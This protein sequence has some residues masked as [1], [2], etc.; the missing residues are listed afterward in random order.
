MCGEVCGEVEAE[1]WEAVE[2][3]LPGRG[4]GTL[5]LLE[6]S[7]VSAREQ[8]KR[9]CFK[10]VYFTD[11][12]DIFILYMYLHTCSTYC[13]MGVQYVHVWQSRVEIEHYSVAH[14][15]RDTVFKML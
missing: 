6:R 9:T 5:R 15:N 4:R 1:R 13:S 12:V 3:A 7:L 14:F 11:N 8:E 2:R 10:L